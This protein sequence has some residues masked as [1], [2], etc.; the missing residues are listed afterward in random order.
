MGAFI[1]TMDQVLKGFLTLIFCCAITAGCGEGE[2]DSQLHFWA[3]PK[4][5]DWQKSLTIRSFDG[6]GLKAQLMVP[7][8]KV[9]PGPR[10]AIIFVNSWTLNEFEYTVQAIR[11]VNKGYIVLSYATR[12]FGGSGGLVSAAS[13]NDIRDVSHI[14]DWLVQQANVDQSKIGMSGVSYGGGISLLA[15]A[16]DERIATVVALSGWADMEHAL[17]GDET[18]RKVWI[19]LLI[20]SGAVTG[21]LDPE[22][23]KIYRS[24]RSQTNLDYFSEWAKERSVIHLVDRINERQAPVFIANNFDDQLFPPNQML[25]FFSRLTGPKKFVVNQG[26]HASAEIGGILGLPSRIWD[27]AIRWFD[28]WFYRDRNGILD[29]KPLS[30]ERGGRLEFYNSLP[31]STQSMDL[32]LEPLNRLSRVSGL[33]LPG[34]QGILAINGRR[35]SG[36]TTGV[37]LLSTIINAHTPFKIR[38]KISDI[39]QRY[40]AVYSSDQLKNT[41][42]LRG[43]PRVEAWIRPQRQDTQLMAYLYVV[44]WKGWGEL[45]T[46]GVITL[47]GLPAGKPFKVEFDLN[48]LSID[49][50]KGKRLALVIDSIDPLYESVATNTRSFDLLHGPELRTKLFLPD[51]AAHDL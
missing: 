13:P 43:T 37:P 25:N 19:E 11:M 14:I 46:H 8:S 39:D 21:R 9:F 17:Y 47:R 31:N 51:L 6:T 16:N 40:G 41:S 10:P 12:G 23:S 5:Y 22:F 32:P 33:N 30:M 26:I 35:D 29:E 50:P 48:A 49:I 1:M 42:Q 20:G 45:A 4:P 2:N 15:L 24:V 7:N 44:D 28:Y 34:V 38:K 27:D 36:A 18:I 3:K